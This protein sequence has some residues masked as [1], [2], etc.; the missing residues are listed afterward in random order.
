MDYAKPIRM[1]KV[2]IEI[3]ENLKLVIIGDYWDEETMEEIVEF[4]C[5]YQDSFPINFS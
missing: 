3:E 4:L 1:R 5:E 2:N